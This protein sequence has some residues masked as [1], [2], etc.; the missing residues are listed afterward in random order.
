MRRTPAAVGS[1]VFFAVAPGGVAGFGPWWVTRWRMADLPDGLSW[2]AVPLRV[3]GVVLVL[4]GGAV[5]VDAFVRFVTEGFGTPA[6]VAPPEHLVVGGLYR[7]VRNPMYVGVLAAIVGQGLLLAR[8][9]LL[10]YAAIAFV[11]VFCFVRVY[12]EPTL[13]RS[14]GTEYEEYR[15]AVPGWWPRLR[16]WVRTSSG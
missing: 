11:A 1:A 14:F 4:A 15:A 9:E 2:A 10:W 3:A 13:R 6:P 8:S 12:E 7:Y 5:L 16:P